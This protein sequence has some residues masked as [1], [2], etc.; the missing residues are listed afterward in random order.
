MNCQRN[1]VH[2]RNKS[3]PGASPSP[4]ARFS[5]V[6]LDVVGP[7]PPST[8]YTDLT[9][10]DRYT[11]WAEAIPLTNVQAETVLKPFVSRWVVIFGAPSTVTTDRGAQFESALIQTLLSFLDCMCIRTTAYHPAATGWLGI[12]IAS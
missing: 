10:V 1:K 11:R 2:R 9:F 8:N 4:D 6:H 3:P 7:M 12:S 5:H